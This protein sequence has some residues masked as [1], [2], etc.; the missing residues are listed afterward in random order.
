MKLFYDKE[1]DSAYIQLS[2][3]KPDGVIEVSDFVNLDTMKDGQLVG[4]EL[5]SVSKKFSVDS[6]FKFQVDVESVKSSY[7]RNKRIKNVKK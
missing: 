4:I 1:S 7:K 5:L 3:Q 2:T 6:L